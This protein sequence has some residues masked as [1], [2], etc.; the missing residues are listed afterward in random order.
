MPPRLDSVWQGE[1][2]GPLQ[3]LGT[4][5]MLPIVRLEAEAFS[6][7]GAELLREVHEGEGAWASWTQDRA[8]LGRANNAWFEAVGIARRD[9]AA[10]NAA[11]A[12]RVRLAL[13]LARLAWTYVANADHGAADAPY[14]AALA[15]VDPLVESD[16][17]RYAPLRAWLLSERAYAECMEGRFRESVSDL[18]E[19]GLLWARH[20][21]AD[22]PG[23][24]AQRFVLAASLGGM[25]HRAG[26]TAAAL[27]M[28]TRAIDA[29]GP[30]LLPAGGTNPPGEPPGGA[31]SMPSDRLL[32]LLAGCHYRLGELHREIGAR[33]ESVQAYRRA[34][35]IWRDLFRTHGE[36]YRLDCTQALG[37]LAPALA[38]L[39]RFDDAIAAWDEMRD[40]LAPLLESDPARYRPVVADILRSTAEA[41]RRLGDEVRALA[42]ESEAAA[43]AQP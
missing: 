3:R 41:R 31:G 36:R 21:P 17:A 1:D 7:N 22:D 5:R 10:T 18:Q 24:E 8:A 26:E 40:L 34:A 11:P 25:L 37:R 16:P 14:R 29:L 30:F 6:G 39:D 2:R 4:F 12:A 33:L 35:D 9:A 32:D 15:A 19:A 28:T 20:A 13:C 38:E 27:I 42:L 43:L 23:C